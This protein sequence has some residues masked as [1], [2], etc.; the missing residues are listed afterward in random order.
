MA[1]LVLIPDLEDAYY[2]LVSLPSTSRCVVH[3]RNTR[4]RLQLSSLAFPQ[5]LAALCVDC[6]PTMSTDSSFQPSLFDFLFLAGT[7]STVF[8]ACPQLQPFI[9]RLSSST[10]VSSSPHHVHHFGPMSE[11]SS[12]HPSPFG[13]NICSSWFQ[14][15]P[16]ASQESSSTSVLNVCHHV[17]YVQPFAFLQLLTSFAYL[18]RLSSDH[19]HGC[20]NSPFADQYL[21]SLP[22]PR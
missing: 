17:D 18:C 3:T 11:I 20:K 6:P 7:V 22:S 12:S 19:V 9:L 1:N 21:C 2:S 8:G 15:T 10:P 13:L 16:E 4:F 14:L 5:S